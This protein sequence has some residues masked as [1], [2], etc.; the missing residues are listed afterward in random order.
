MCKHFFLS[1]LGYKGDGAVWR[2]LNSASPESI[3][4]GK[5]G[6]GRH[7]PKNKIDAEIINKHVLSFNPAIHHYRREHAPKR[8]YLPSDITIKSMHMDYNTQPEVQKVSLERY[9]QAVK[10]HNISFAVLGCEECETCKE[11]KLHQKN[12]TSAENCDA[13]KIQNLHLRQNEEARNEYKKDAKLENSETVIV[14]VDLQKVLLL[15]RMPGVKSCAFTPRLVTFNYTVASLGKAKAKDSV[16]IWNESIS[17]R[18]AE[19]IASALKCFLLQNRDTRHF[20]IWA[21]NCGAQN[22][23]WTLFTFLVQIINSNDICADKITIKFLVSGHT[24]MSA[25]S[26]HHRIE[27]E[28]KRTKDVYDWR[29]FKEVL[30]RVGRLNVID[31]H[32]ENFM[33]WNDGSSKPKLKQNAIKLNEICV[34]E[35]RRGSRTLFCKRSFEHDFTEVDFL[36]KKFDLSFNPQERVDNRG[37]SSRKKMKF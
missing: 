8:L 33:A 31:M 13:C 11:H 18:K 20:V 14:S 24:F 32:R 27:Q 25:D 23:N 4:P 30:I 12:C 7:E 16:V 15:P 17:G 19:D 5:D 9:R 29:D 6:R 22:K 3:S 2:C 1:T 10:F 36:K 35:F 28:L 21:D 37:V 26:I 34:V